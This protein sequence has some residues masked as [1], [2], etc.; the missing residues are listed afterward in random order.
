MIASVVRK[1]NLHQQ[2]SDFEYW[3]GQ[4]YETRIAA[5]LEIRREYHA[6]IDS[7]QKGS[8]VVQSGF[9]RVYRIVER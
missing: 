5:L 2:S 9:Q 6:W 3:R 1:V 8:T 7:Q 4:P